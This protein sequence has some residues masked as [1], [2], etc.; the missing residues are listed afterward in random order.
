[1]TGFP[2]KDTFPDWREHGLHNVM[3]TG[4][5]APSPRVH[6]SVHEFVGSGGL[7][8][9]TP[10]AMG[11]CHVHGDLAGG[12]ELAVLCGLP[13]HPGWWQAFRQQALVAAARLSSE[14]PDSSWEA[15]ALGSA[16]RGWRGLLSKREPR[17]GAA[18]WRG[19]PL[20]QAWVHDTPVCWMGRIL[21]GS[22]F[23]ILISRGKRLPGV[24]ARGMCKS[25]V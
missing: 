12:R 25:S 21:T 1:M 11:L 5:P 2:H 18:V 10:P 22:L 17:A 14:K 4:T 13:L 9:S 19:G 6:A 8:A 7:V 3:A 23:C 16:G 20:L 15:N 24:L